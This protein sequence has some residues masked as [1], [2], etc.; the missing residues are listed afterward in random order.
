M[1]GPPRRRKYVAFVGAATTNTRHYWANAG[2]PFSIDSAERGVAP[3]RRLLRLSWLFAPFREIAATTIV[4]IG[5]LPT[6]A[7]AL[8]AV[9]WIVI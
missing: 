9:G 3:V 7:A 8:R 6:A 4:T 2:L 5:K 1:V